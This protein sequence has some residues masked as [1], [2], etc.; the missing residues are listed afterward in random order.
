[1]EITTSIIIIIIITRTTAIYRS[2]MSE[3]QPPEI[4]PK[5]TDE[6][7]AL[8]SMALLA[9]Q[10]GVQP[11]LTRRYTPPGIIPSTVILM[12]EI[13][14]FGIA[15]TMLR[16][17]GATAQATKGRFA[18]LSVRGYPKQPISSMHEHC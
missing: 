1:M 4:P 12:Q 17:S 11:I 18:C 5:N 2:I 6:R 7:K 3:K 10:F 16:G 15:Y 8:F 9:L 14:K 13:V